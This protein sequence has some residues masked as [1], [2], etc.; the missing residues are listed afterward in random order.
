MNIWEPKP[1]GILWATPGLL[2]D[3]LPFYIY[4]YTYTYKTC[5]LFVV[6]SINK[7][8]SCAENCVSLDSYAASSGNSLPTFRDNVTFRKMSVR[9]YHYSLDNNLE[10]RNSGLLRPRKPEMT[11]NLLPLS[12]VNLTL[13]RAQ[14]N[15][16]QRKSFALL[17]NAPA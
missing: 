12:L 10:E 11:L 16:K 6:T 15:L 4:I 5:R 13:R 3:P 2:R 17:L 8:L 14:L 1:P 7:T 9:N